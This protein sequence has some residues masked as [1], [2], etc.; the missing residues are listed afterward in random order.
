[1][2]V[3]LLENV[4][5]VGKRGQAKEVKDGYFLNFLAP[6]NLALPFG[7]PVAK[8]L[9]TEITQTEGKR[10]ASESA[11]E[12]ELVAQNGR[13]L[14]VEGKA[15][16]SG[17]LFE[18]IKAERLAVLLGLPTSAVKLRAPIKTVGEHNIDLL[19]HGRAVASLKV[20]VTPNN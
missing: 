2:R 7:H 15:S 9:Q 16:K 17:K 4:L 8:K 18:Q 13:R 6:R 12:I 3:V 10:A 11:L 1:M 20:D 14:R 19:L 5:G